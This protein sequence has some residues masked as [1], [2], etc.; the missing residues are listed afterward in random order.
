MVTLCQA[1][2]TWM[3]RNNCQQWS[4]GSRS[5]ESW[6]LG[7]SRYRYT[8]QAWAS[9]GIVIDFLMPP[10]KKK[11]G[12]WTSSSHFDP[13]EEGFPATHNDSKVIAELLCFCFYTFGKYIYSEN[14]LWFNVG[15]ILRTTAAWLSR[16]PRHSS[17][18]QRDLLAQSTGDKL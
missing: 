16:F 3:M 10:P 7:D 17:N 4:W 2:S 13:E 15:K 8:A 18:T 5:H 6:K 1:F 11:Q 14:Y 12:G 9:I